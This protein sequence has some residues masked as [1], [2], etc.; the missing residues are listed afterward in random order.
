[1]FLV[2]ICIQKVAPGIYRHC[3][4]CDVPHLHG[5]NLP[6]EYRGGDEYF[7]SVD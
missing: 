4:G 3:D 7:H 2:L 1:M 6:Y 5:R